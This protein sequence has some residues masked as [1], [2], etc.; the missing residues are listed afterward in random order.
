[1]AHPDTNPE[2]NA[3]PPDGN[4]TVPLPRRRASSRSFDSFHSITTVLANIAVVLGL[5]F[6]AGQIIQYRAQERVR[7][8]VA[9]TDVISSPQFLSAYANV[10]ESQAHGAEMPQNDLLFVA[11]VYDGIAI[12][13]LRGVADGAI[14]RSRLG[15]SIPRLL[16]ILKHE[17]WSAQSTEN[18]R[19]LVTE[20]KLSEQFPP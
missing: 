15:S 2:Q 17:N 18:L 8:A 11:N 16:A 5:A 4:T 14:I 19:T 13:Y 20:L 10:T 9:A 12:L 6:A 3:Q 7:I 1:M